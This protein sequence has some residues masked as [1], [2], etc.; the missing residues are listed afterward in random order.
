MKYVIINL[1]LLAYLMVT[2]YG[3]LYN[4]FVDIV[5]NRPI[6]SDR[7]MTIKTIGNQF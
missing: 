6:D 5:T 3:D 2:Q 4:L 1:Y 7:A